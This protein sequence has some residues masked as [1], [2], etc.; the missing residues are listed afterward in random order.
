[1]NSVTECCLLFFFV[2]EH[3]TKKEMS[4]KIVQE[5]KTDKEHNA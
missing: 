1:M 5:T 2:E 3:S 4:E